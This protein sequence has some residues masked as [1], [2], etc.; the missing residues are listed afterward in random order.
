[1]IF[2]TFFKFFPEKIIFYQ[3]IFLNETNKEDS[4]NNKVHD[5]I[6]SYNK[7]PRI[8]YVFCSQNF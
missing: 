2:N 3:T 4:C 1:M 7:M 5:S 6:K 8:R